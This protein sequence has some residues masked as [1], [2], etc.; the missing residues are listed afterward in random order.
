MVKTV[1]RLKET[2]AVYG[3]ARVL[4]KEPCIRLGRAADLRRENIYLLRSSSKEYNPPGHNRYSTYGY[5]SECTDTPLSIRLF[6][7]VY[8]HYTPR[9]VQSTGH[10][11]QKRR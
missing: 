2:G 4:K 11:V 3:Y 10:H 5:F 1:C 7:P 6:L 8:G 9:S